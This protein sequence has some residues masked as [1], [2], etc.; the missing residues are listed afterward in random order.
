MTRYYQLSG[1]GNDFLAIVEPSNRPSPEKIS[2]WC[3][4]GLSAG[5]DG[6]FLLERSPSG[7]VMTHYNSDGTA[8]ELCLNGTRCAVQL[9]CHLGWA[10]EEIDILTGAGT[11][12][13][14]RADASRIALTLPIPEPPQ[15]RELTVGSEVFTAWSI[16]V[17]VPH[18]VL[19][20]TESLESAPVAD[21]GGKLRSH[22]DLGFEGANA[23]FVRIIAPDRLEIRTFERGVE[24]ETL[25]CGT[26]VL[27]ATAVGLD[28]DR[29]S[30][31]VRALTLG[32]FE[33]RVDS[34]P[35][36]ETPSWIFTGD[37]RMIS[38]GRLM[39]G[40]LDLPDRARWSD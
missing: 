2:A 13:G 19:L 12:H 4:R 22:P 39:D 15:I 35:D 29:L 14:R 7:A 11:L 20:W 8:A 37:A 10:S 25:A 28:L 3:R 38:E 31:P 32:G 17:G 30:L 23:D 6:L 21:L 40:A 36:K 18:V 16:R 34:A 24:A 1:G 27:A 9:A 26:G 33:L 5:A